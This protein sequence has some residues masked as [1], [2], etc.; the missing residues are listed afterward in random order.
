MRSATLTGIL[1][2]AAP[3]L[4]ACSF[5][6][7]PDVQD[8][9][10]T[11]EVDAGADAAPDAMPI[12]CEPDTIVCDDAVGRYVDCDSSGNPE[13]VIE[14]ALGCSDTVEKCIDIDPSNGLAPYL[15]IARSDANV[16][17]IAFTGASTIDTVTGAATNDGV[18]VTL[19]SEV[20]G[21]VRIFLFKELSIAG[22]L[23][24]TGPTHMLALVVDGDVTITGTLDVSADGLAPG[25]GGVLTAD[26]ACHGAGTVLPG[27]NNGG[28]G[29]GRYDAGA[30][31]GAAFGQSAGFAGGAMSRDS[32]LVPLRPGCSGGGVVHFINMVNYF[33]SGGAGGGAI[34][35]VSSSRIALTGIGKIDA[36]GGGGLGNTSYEMPGGGGGSGGAIFLEAPAVVLDGAGVVVSTKGGGGAAAGNDQATHDGSDGGTGPGAASGGVNAPRAA[37]G[38]GGTESATPGVGG[39]GPNS[40]Y[41]HGGGGGGAVGEARLL[42]GDGTATPMNGA[43]IRSRFTTGTVGTRLV[44]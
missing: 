17:S 32:D 16:P 40:S 8:D 44:P 41:P 12:D 39:A 31:G 42:T 15:D 7:P 18:A 2:L 3:M 37:G 25:P 34:Q 14:C 20:V 10:G 38:P 22:T 6:P 4:G 36:S 30:T 29:A 24:V 5:D 28:G 21:D 33:S 35:I 23:K 1:A 13:L 43:A 26:D 27:S 9:G 11:D 19:P